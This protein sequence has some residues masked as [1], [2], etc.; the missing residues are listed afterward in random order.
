MSCRPLTLITVA[1]IAFHS[2]P[3]PGQE[4]PSAV[5]FQRDV[6]P[7]LET[8]C[9]RCHHPGNKKGDLSLATIAD[10]KQARHVVPGKPGESTSC[11]VLITRG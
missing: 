4:R 5:S 10:L 2:E 9:L 8:H 7:I 3:L 11:W 1:L 6:A